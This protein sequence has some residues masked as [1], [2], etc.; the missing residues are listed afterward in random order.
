M[1]K[2]VTVKVE[3]VVP[4]GVTLNGDMAQVTV[5]VTGD[6][7]HPKL[8]AALYPF[9]GVTVIVVVVLFPAAVVADDGFAAK[10]KSVNIKL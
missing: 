7:E 6:T 10:L 5:A 4:G 9:N 8:I 1:V 2:V 3:A